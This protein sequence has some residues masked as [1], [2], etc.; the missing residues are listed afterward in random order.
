MSN[1]TSAGGRCVST[2][3]RSLGASIVVRSTS[4]HPAKMRH[5]ATVAQRSIQLCHAVWCIVRAVLWCHCYPVTNS[6]SSLTATLKGTKRGRNRTW[7]SVSYIGFARPDDPG[8]KVG[9]IR[10]RNERHQSCWNRSR[11]AVFS[12]QHNKRCFRKLR[13]LQNI[14]QA[15]ATR[16]NERF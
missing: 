9:T 12:F 5:T 7:A 4:S 13:H 11:P 3:W 14:R 15:A 6:I 10:R 16:V 2:E 1:K 8:V